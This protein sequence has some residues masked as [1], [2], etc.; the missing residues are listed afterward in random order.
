[1]QLRS[2]QLLHPPSESRAV[3]R[4]SRASNSPA[5]RCTCRDRVGE[6][7]YPLGGPTLAAG[8]AESK[9]HSIRVKSRR[10]RFQ[11]LSDS[12]QIPVGLESKSRQCRDKNPNFLRVSESTWGLPLYRLWADLLRCD[13]G[14]KCWE[15]PV[16]IGPNSVENLAC[17]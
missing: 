3:L 7:Q 15:S 4:R 16:Q 5:H 6:G 12:S 10:I 9:S 11:I 8:P 17:P 13:F 2:D 14:K 1:M